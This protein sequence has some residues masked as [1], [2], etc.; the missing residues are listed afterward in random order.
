EP[1][2]TQAEL[3]RLLE[4]LRGQ[5]H[6]RLDAYTSAPAIPARL[7]EAMRYS[8]LAPGKRIRP[9]LTLLACQTCGGSIGD[10]LPAACAVEMIHTYSLITD[11]LPALDDDALRRGRLT[12]HKRLC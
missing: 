7:R 4:D 11:R 9:C 6:P 12:A 10:A 8:L 5:L 3:A 1:I 2:V